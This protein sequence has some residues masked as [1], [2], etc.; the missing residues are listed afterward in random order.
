MGDSTL[1]LRQVK[2]NVEII[3]FSGEVREHMKIVQGGS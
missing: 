1:G 3:L 2:L